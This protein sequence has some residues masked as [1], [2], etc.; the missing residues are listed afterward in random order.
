MPQTPRPAIDVSTLPNVVFEYRSNIWWATMGIVAIE[1]F[2]FG[3]IVA[4][5]FYLRTRVN[6]WP[7][8]LDPPKLLWGTLNL[9]LTMVSG[10]PNMWVKK[11][12]HKLDVKSV[13][14]GLIV[15]SVIAV[16]GLG[17]RAMEFTALNCRWDANA[18][19]S[20]VWTILGLHTAH[21]LTDAYDTWVLAGLFFTDR[22]EGRRFVDAS[23]NADYWNFV[24]VSWVVIYAVIY[25]A[26]RIL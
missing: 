23:E 10:I 3:V 14:V 4:A 21:L 26:P 11:V 7:P 1:G 19:A 22:I 16:L 17:L 15:M 25:I 9:G 18:Y 12:A 13:R 5:Y 2:M 8:G 6:D 20:I 24:V